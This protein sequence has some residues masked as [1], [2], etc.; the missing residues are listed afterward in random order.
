LNA[1]LLQA[2]LDLI[3]GPQG[4]VVI[5]AFALRNRIGC[6]AGRRGIVVAG[7]LHLRTAAEPKR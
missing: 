2:N 6:G 3:W 4:L 7:L 5:D 1:G